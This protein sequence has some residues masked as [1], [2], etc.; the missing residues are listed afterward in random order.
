MKNV[1]AHV[2]VHGRVQG[3]WFRASTEREA[4]RLGVNGWVK[5]LPN[6]TVEAVFEG[7]EEHVKR[8]VAWCR[9]GP[10]AAHVTKVDVDYE[11]YTGEFSGLESRY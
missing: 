9:R 2:I 10:S 8:V 11:S 4:S 1:R 5:N 3:V 7:E 6:G